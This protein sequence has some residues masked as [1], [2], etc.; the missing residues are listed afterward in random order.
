VLVVASSQLT[1]N[2]L[3]RA[4]NAPDM[5]SM[6]MMMPLPGDEK[7]LLLAQPYAQASMT[8]TILAVKNVLD[9]MAGEQAMSVCP[10]PYGL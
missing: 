9:W 5:G 4:G 10:L 3:A 6:G 8:S 2:P 1:A 7:L